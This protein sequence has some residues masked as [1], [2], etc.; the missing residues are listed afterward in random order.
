[1]NLLIFGGT[2]FVGR[3]IAAAALA[4]GHAEMFFNQGQTI[5]EAELLA[6]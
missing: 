3:R 4:A 5:P 1:M 2:K 6:R